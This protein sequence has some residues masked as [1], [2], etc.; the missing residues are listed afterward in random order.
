M[1]RWVEMKISLKVREKL[2]WRQGT[3]SVAQA[4]LI[5]NSTVKLKTITRSSLKD[6]SILMIHWRILR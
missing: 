3:M 1:A 2:E 5:Q 4:F 6:L